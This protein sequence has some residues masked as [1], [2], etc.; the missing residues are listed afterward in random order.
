[1]GDV[2]GM[3]EAGVAAVG[4][5]GFVAAGVGAVAGVGAAAGME[6]VGA[7][8]IGG[9]G[10]ILI[11]IGV[12]EAA[13]TGMV[14][15]GTQAVTENS[16]IGRESVRYLLSDLRRSPQSIFL[17]PSRTGVDWGFATEARGAV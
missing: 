14:M 12:T 7:I 9:A 5:V 15:E 16:R 17:K 2:D 10:A 3:E 1:M 4:V 8:L 11:L 6:G 13:I